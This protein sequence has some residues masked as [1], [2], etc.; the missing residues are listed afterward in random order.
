MQPYEFKTSDQE[1]GGYILHFT[2][3]TS[4]S[5]YSPLAVKLAIQIDDNT[6]F[7]ADEIGIVAVQTF[8]GGQSR[9]LENVLNVSQIR[10]K[11]FSVG[12][13]TSKR[14]LVS[15]EQNKSP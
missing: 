5:E 12:A 4:R 7:Y 6:L 10:R 13:T 2:E 15:L 8:L 9:N 1:K 14:F 11:L 3:N